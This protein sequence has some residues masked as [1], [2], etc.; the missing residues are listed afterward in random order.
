MIVK[1][2]TNHKSLHQVLFVKNW[3]TSISD[4]ITKFSLH[5][6]STE[7]T[8]KLQVV[9]VIWHKAAS[10]PLHL[11]HRTWTVQSYSPGGTNVPS[12]V[13]TLAPPGEY[14]WT[15]ASFGP[16]KSTTKMANQLVKLF[17]HSSLQKVLILYNGYSYPPK[18]P[19]PWGFG[20]HLIH[21]SLDP[22]ECTS[23][24]ESRSVQLFLQGSLVWQTD[25]QTTL[26]GR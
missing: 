18:L 6:H 3:A 12:H 9:K 22:P 7:G 24:T 2:V 8:T 14:D 10:L 17:L 21:G 19:L 16:P 20:P 5:M 15:Y 11:A 4:L 13:R 1:T 23:Q 25:R 26:F